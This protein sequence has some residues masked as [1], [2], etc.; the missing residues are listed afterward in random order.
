MEIFERDKDFEDNLSN[1]ITHTTQLCYNEINNPSSVFL[2]KKLQETISEIP[3]IKIFIK[4]IVMI[5][6][7]AIR[8]D[9]TKV[10]NSEKI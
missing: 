3:G 8:D 4:F 1:L 5:V 7:Y 10:I 6:L 2:T 9:I